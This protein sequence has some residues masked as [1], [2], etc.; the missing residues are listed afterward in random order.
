MSTFQKITIVGNL[1]DDPQTHYFEGGGQITRFSVATTERWTDKN[2]GEK[3]ELTEWHRVTANGKTAELCDK[4]LAKG[5][6]VLV[7][8][9]NRTRKWTDDKSVDHYT[10]EIIVR[11][12]VFLT[13][14]GQNGG[15]GSTNTGSAVDQHFAKQNR[16]ENA[17]N[18]F[19]NGDFKAKGSQSFQPGNEDDDDLPF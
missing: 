10:T 16:P 3:K 7:E 19:I 9:R 11:E 8:G 2:S 1:G 4:Y 15:Q 5:S 18:E 6:K 13:P 14:K 17:G 12:I